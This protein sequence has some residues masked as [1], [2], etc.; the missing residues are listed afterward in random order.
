MVPHPGRESAGFPPGGGN[1]D[2]THAILCSI[3]EK[4]IYE[5]FSRL[6]TD[7][8]AY[9]AMSMV[10]NLYGDGHACER[11]AEIPERELE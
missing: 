3:K 9:E 7:A 4:K 6:L 10:S 5:E 2:N 11:T 8:K 1:T